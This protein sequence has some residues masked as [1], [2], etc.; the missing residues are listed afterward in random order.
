M[1]FNISIKN[2]ELPYDWKLAHVTPIPKSNDKSDPLNYRPISLLSILV[3]LLEKHMYSKILEHLK[4]ISFLSNKQW[5]FTKGK[6]TTGALLTA[7]HN[8]H[9]LLEDGQSV[10]AVF[11]DF[12][13]AFDK[14]PHSILMSK[15]TN[16]N[17]DLHLVSWVASY[18]RNR[19]QYVIING[20]SSNISEVV[21]G[22][23]QGSVLG[24]LLF[25]I[26]IN[27][28]DLHQNEGSLL[29]YA[30]DLLLYH[31]I[32]SPEDYLKLQGDIDQLQA[33]S[34]RNVL[35]FNQS[36]CKYMTISRK[37]SPPLPNMFLNISGRPLLK[38][39]HYKYLGVWISHDLSWSKHIEG[40]CMQK[41]LQAGCRQFYGHS[42]LEC[43]RQLYISL[44]R[45]KLEYAAPVWDPHQKTNSHKIEKVQ[46]FALKICT[47]L[48]NRDYDSLLDTVDLPSLSTRRLYLKLS[49]L[50]Q[51]INGNFKFPDPPLERRVCPLN[52][53]STKNIQFKDQFAEQ[54][55][56]RTLFSQKQYLYGMNYHWSCRKVHRFCHLREMYSVTCISII[57]VFIFNLYS[58]L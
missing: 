21:S 54:M 7:V 50:Y 22:V 16:L 35:L 38:V 11:F 57:L 48:W 58:L 3:K 55:H 51:V 39:D 40:M 9:K 24:P 5:G 23:P 2:C 41:C 28:I 37:F 34:E 19:S 36:K 4:D 32:Q 53:R 31:P 49:Y 6:S 12:K 10:C 17:L 27:D 47:K 44:V 30:D 52:L 1:L 46:K 29:L 43:L 56:M 45:S 33:W 25:L 8:W 20:K 18:L 42:S 15:L 13:K 26:Y 14:V